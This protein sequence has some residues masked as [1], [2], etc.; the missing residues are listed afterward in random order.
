MIT[1]ADGSNLRKGNSNMQVDSVLVEKDEYAINMFKDNGRLMLQ[2][3]QKSANCDSQAACGSLNICVLLFFAKNAMIMFC[4]R[5]K[6]KLYYIM[7]LSR[8]Y[9]YI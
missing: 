2:V 9:L 8:P 1:D 5:Y 7:S 3:I 4:H 6:P